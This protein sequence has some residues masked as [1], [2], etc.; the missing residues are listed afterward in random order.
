M[1]RIPRMVR[2]D[3]GQKTVYHVMSRTALDG[4]PFKDAEK[5]QLVRVIKRFSMIYAVDVLGMA[6]MSN[7]FHILAQISPGFMLSDDEVKRRFIL[8][9]NKG[10]EFPEGQLDAF[11]ERFSSLSHYVKDIKQTF[12]R[13]YNQQKKRK[14][15]LWG[16]RFKSVIVEKGS[17]VINCLAYI[18]LNAV[19]AG[20]VKRPEDYRW[21]SIGYHVQ[22]GNKDDFLSLDFGL[23]E[24]G[25]GN[26]QRLKKYREYLYHAGALDKRG[27]A[28]ISKKV[29]AEESAE[30]FELDRIRRFRYRTRYFTDSGVIGSKA[31]VLETYEVY[32]DRFF[33]SRER[34]PK[35]VKGINGMYSLKRLTEA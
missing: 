29:L 14:G 6:I 31:F 21:C 12:S 22:A 13:I 35:R 15:T 18:D 27:K 34:V 19:R 4:F 28:K 26:S 7:H 2:T 25:V 9:Y 8:L 10:T 24:F 23:A 16:E 17:T 5:D 30:G 11:R 1:P 32:K 3:S 33:A 20:I